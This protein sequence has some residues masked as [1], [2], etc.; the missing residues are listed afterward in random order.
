MTDIT[1][2]GRSAASHPAEERLFDVRIVPHRSLSARNFKI[3]MGGFCLVATLSSLPF[4][5]LG[6]WPVAGF[7]GLDVL[8]IYWAFRANFRAAQAYEDVQVTPLELLLA[9]VNAAGARQEWRFHPAWVR[10][11]R[12][13]HFEFGLQHLSLRSRGHA[14]EVAAFLGPDAKADFAAS[15]THA[16]HQARRGPRFS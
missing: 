1:I 9:K 12:V 8:L 14:V 2:T 15:L 7:M 5:V 4:V 6:A 13:E 10:L 11:D 16:L 3:L